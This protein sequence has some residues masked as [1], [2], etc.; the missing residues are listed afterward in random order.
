MS[1][2]EQV[3][4]SVSDYFFI[5]FSPEKY[6]LSKFETHIIQRVSQARVRITAKN[7]YSQSTTHS[8]KDSALISPV[9]FANSNH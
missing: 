1:L 5:V 6:S 2:V 8:P 7:Y 3:K 4:S 9:C